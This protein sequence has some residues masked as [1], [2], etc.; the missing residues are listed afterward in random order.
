MGHRDESAEIEAIRSAVLAWHA[1]S[2]RVLPWREDRRDPYRVLVAETM[3][4]Q[5][6]VSAVIPYYR[7][8]LE[9][10]PTIDALARAPEADV[11]KQWEGLGYYRRARQLHA[12]AKVVTDRFAGSIPADEA[13]LMSLPGV[14]R[15]IAGAVRSFAFDQPAP[16]LEANTIR[17]IARLIGLRDDV[18]KSASLQRLWATAE[19]LV[20]ESEPGTFNQA[21]M[22]LGSGVCTPRDPSCQTCPI[23]DCCVAFRN[24]LTPEIPYRPVRR[25]PTP[26]EELAIALARASDNS[27]LLVRRPAEGLWSSF[28]EL[29]TFW[30]AGADPA[31]RAANGAFLGKTDE[32]GERIRSLFGIET[33]GMESAIPRTLEYVVTRYRIRL[34][35]IRGCVREGPMGSATLDCP[36]GWAEARFVRLEDW[37]RLTMPSAHRKALKWLD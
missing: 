20:P 13:D 2:G 21:M 7:K 26:G 22:D 37:G 29:P 33:E 35:V 23:A 30:I 5:T 19:K 25:P 17:L 31:Q 36:A 34:H 9:R 18:T 12:L 3:L 27:L 15:Y 28:W 1:R 4:V 10:F 11:L 32:V 8:F 16:I 14:G 24:G 6:T